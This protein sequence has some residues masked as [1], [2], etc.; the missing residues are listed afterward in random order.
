[1][2]YIF[3]K[4]P[5]VLS[6]KEIIDKSFKRAK[7]IS[8]AKHPDKVAMFRN[9][10]INKL[11]SMEKSARDTLD[12]YLKKFPNLNVLDP[13]HKELVEILVDRDQYKMAL[14][15]VKWCRD[16]IV[17]LTTKTIKDLEKTREMD[18]FARIMNSYFGRFSSFVEGIK[19]DL[20]YL[21]IA[22]S[23]LINIPDVD[24]E[25][26]TIVVSGFPN[27][28]KSELVK[29]ISSAKPEIAPYPFTTKGILIGHKYFGHVK[30]QIIDT[31]GLLDRP[32]D[33]RNEM[34]KQAILAIKHLAD[35]IIYILDPSETCGYALEKQLS[36]LNEIKNNFQLALIEVENKMDIFRSESTRLKISAKEKINIDELL[37]KIENVIGESYG[38]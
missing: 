21:K 28:G 30:A 26:F 3:S 9:W 10:D 19:K 7:K 22:R 27:V 29:S 33:E 35:V 12:S 25:L 31:P 37:K 6:S 5:Q 18:D 36:L 2:D 16:S 13:F 8:L 15:S 17:K 1:M 32:F 23:K 11:K 38:K 34:E 14:G 4:I 20:D 24:P